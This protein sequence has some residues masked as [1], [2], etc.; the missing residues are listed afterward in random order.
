MGAQM[1]KLFI[2]LKGK[3]EKFFGPTHK[4]FPGK[5]VMRRLEIFYIKHFFRQTDQTFR[6]PK[7][8]ER[9]GVFLL[10]LEPFF[11]VFW[12]SQSMAFRHLHMHA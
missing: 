6:D 8:W 5:M 1:M 7:F 12:P 11:L 3:F 10:N 9:G 2:T 4:N